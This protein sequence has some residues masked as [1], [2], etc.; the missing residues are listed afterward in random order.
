MI[1]T[2]ALTLALVVALQ[3]IV[4]GQGLIESIFGQGGFGG[5][6]QSQQPMVQQFNDPALYSGG[7]D[8]NSPYNPQ[9]GQPGAYGPPGYGQPGA[10]P[11]QYQQDYPQGGGVYSDW[12][13][14][15]PATVG[16]QPPAN[17]QSQPPV[18]YSAPPQQPAPSPPQRRAVRAPR[19]PSAPAAG[20]AATPPGQAYGTAPQPPLRAGQYS[21]Q[22][23]PPAAL[24]GG[25]PERLPPGATQITTT[26]PEG[27]TVQYFPPPPDALQPMPAVQAP[28]RQVRPRQAGAAARQKASAPQSQPQTAD[29]GTAG[30][31]MPKPVEIPAGRDPRSGWTAR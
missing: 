7:N 17:Y 25:D 16:G 27:T 22:Q 13:R 12:H 6:T 8:P 3:G 9:A 15:P 20:A 24:N 14:Y 10:A 2:L 1:R 21:P 18:T 28:P 11:Q 29:Q 23:P 26:T 4:Y 19:A 31:A 30:I 5:A